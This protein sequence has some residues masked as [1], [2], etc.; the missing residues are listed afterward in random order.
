MQLTCTITAVVGGKGPEHVTKMSESYGLVKRPLPDRWA[1]G[2][3]ATRELPREGPRGIILFKWPA[4]T[5]TTY[6]VSDGQWTNR[7]S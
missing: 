6:V 5:T 2:L 4:G 1:V 3:P 7:T